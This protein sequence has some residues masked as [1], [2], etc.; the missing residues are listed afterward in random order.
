MNIQY[1]ETFINTVHINFI[2]EFN[3][4]KHNVCVDYASGIQSIDIEVDD[5]YECL[6]D[7]IDSS[8]D[9][10]DRVALIDLIEEAVM[11]QDLEENLEFA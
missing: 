6:Y 4:N 2:V 9:E 5:E 3:G 8:F 7:D 1:R 11:Y 10:S